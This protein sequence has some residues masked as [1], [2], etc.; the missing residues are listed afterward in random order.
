MQD[1][2]MILEPTEAMRLCVWQ[3]VGLE[4]LYKQEMRIYVCCENEDKLSVSF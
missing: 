1:A 2:E 4:K 3:R